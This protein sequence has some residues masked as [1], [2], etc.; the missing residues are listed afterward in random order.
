MKVLVVFDPL[1][2]GDS[3]DAV[4]IIES[5]E[6][7]KWF[8]EHARSIDQNSAVLGSGNELLTIL[9]QVFDHHPTWTDIVVHGRPFTNEVAA[10]I[11]T[12]TAA[13][14]ARDGFKLSRP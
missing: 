7:R 11:A 2:K 1:Y 9:L 5:A 4:W 8:D 3:A 12:D 14:I 13:T 10:E 6:N